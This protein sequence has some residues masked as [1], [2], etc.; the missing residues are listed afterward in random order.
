MKSLIIILLLGCI[1]FSSAQNLPLVQAQASQ[2]ERLFNWLPLKPK[3]ADEDNTD[4]WVLGEC[5]ESP[6]SVSVT[7]FLGAQD[8]NT[9]SAEKLTDGDPTTAW[10]EG[11]ADFGIGEYIEFKAFPLTNWG[12]LN[13]YQKDNTTWENY[14]RVKKMRIFIEGKPAFEVMLEDKMGIQTF[15]LPDNIKIDPQKISTGTKIK[16]VILEIY[17]G[18]KSKDVAI[19]EIFFV[20]C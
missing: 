9:Y 3:G 12:I 1:S 8:R 13:G 18:K 19:S 16:M 7:S 15:Q 2:K 5:S 11:K 14:S 20:G 17:E 4:G 10:A 6:N